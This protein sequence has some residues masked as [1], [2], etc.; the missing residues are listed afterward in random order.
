MGFH[1]RA[2]RYALAYRLHFTVFDRGRA[3]TATH[4]IRNARN[5]QDPKTV[6]RCDMDED[7]SG[8]Q[9]Q[10]QL[11]A[12]VFPAADTA[13]KREKTVNTLF[14]QLSAYAFLVTSTSVGRIPLHFGRITRHAI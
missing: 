13:V 3:P 4:K 14:L 7:V 9:R 5:L 2:K 11:F 1:A 10:R 8:K 6:F 12:S